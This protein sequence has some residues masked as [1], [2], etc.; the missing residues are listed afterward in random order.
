MRQYFFVIAEAHKCQAGERGEGHK[1]AQLARILPQ[2][3][4][5]GR[6]ADQGE[7]ERQVAKL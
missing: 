7:A 6:R 1:V 2:Q 3:S 5:E 4:G